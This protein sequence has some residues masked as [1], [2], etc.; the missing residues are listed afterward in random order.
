MYKKIVLS[1]GIRV[2]T[3][4]MKE[5][6]SIAI[7]IWAGVGGRYEEGREKGAAHFLE[8]IVFKGSEKYSCEEIK[9]LIEGVGGSL[10]AFTSEEQTC[11]YAKIPS[12]HL[13]QTFSVLSNMVFH[14][15]ITQKDV[16]KEKTVIIEEIKMYHDLPQYFVMELLDELLWPG[17]PLGKG[18]A[19]SD[20]TVGAMTHKDLRKFYKNHYSPANIVVSA[21]GKLKHQQI[22]DLVKKELGTIVGE[23]QNCYVKAGDIQ[24][25]P[26]TRFFKKD[27]EQMHLALGMPGVDEENEDK[28]LVTLLSIIL[29]GNMSS[30]L[31]AE[32]REKKGLAYSISCSVKSLHDTGIFMVRAGVDNQKIVEAVA[33]IIKELKK[34][35]KSG[36]SQ[37][38]FVRGKEY[39]LGQLSLGLEDTMDHMLWIGGTLISLNKIETLKNIMRKFDNIKK[40]DVKR[41]ANDILKE[42]RF[43][44]AIVGPLT[45]RQEK[46][47]KDLIG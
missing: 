30:R 25:A 5:R 22:V 17:H 2:V 42:N 13:E 9:E 23:N 21:C 47:L 11:F 29:G 28:Y 18:L 1:N 6:D 26:R 16:A 45:G 37:S 46:E 33:L 15:K 3:H 27:I 39:L 12:K 41:V 34:I 14:P 43:N 10:N 31:F 44:L 32:V 35:K 20:E 38:E 7:G 8:H 4:S 24:Y 19:G 36:I 40:S